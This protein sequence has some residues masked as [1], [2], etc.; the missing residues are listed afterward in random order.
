MEDSPCHP[1]S[2][3]LGRYHLCWTSIMRI[4]LEAMNPHP[5]TTV[6]ASAMSSGAS[7]YVSVRVCIPCGVQKNTSVIAVE[8]PLDITP[9]SPVLSE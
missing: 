3:R 6:S 9:G 1:M 2:V 8:S 4:K 5:P 7:L